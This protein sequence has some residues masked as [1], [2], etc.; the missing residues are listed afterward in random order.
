MYENV[1]IFGLFTE[2]KTGAICWRQSVDLNLNWFFFVSLCLFKGHGKVC[3]RC[4]DV[5]GRQWASC[6]PP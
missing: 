3:S 4:G 1:E 5:N 6:C 2:E